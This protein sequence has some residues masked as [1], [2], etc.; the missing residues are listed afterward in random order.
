MIVGDIPNLNDKSIRFLI[1]RLKLT[2]TDEEATADFKNQIH[3]ATQICR[4]RIDSIAH[5]LMDW[6]KKEE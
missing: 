2:K 4:R 1:D 5:N 3:V 6:L